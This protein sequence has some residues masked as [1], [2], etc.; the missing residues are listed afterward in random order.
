MAP[1]SHR[2]LGFS[3]RAQY[4]LFLGYVI[5]VAGVLCGIALIIMARFDPKGFTIL[6]GAVLEITAPV[7][8][9]GR[10]G[11]RSVRS[12]NDAVYAYFRAGS[13]NAAL[14]AELKTARAK[15]IQARAIARENA[16]L[17]QLL[18]IAD[19]PPAPIAVTRIIGST[20]SNSQRLA[21]LAAGSASGVHS[22]Q[23]VRGAEGLIGRVT[24]VGLNFSYVL[25]ITDSSST[26]PIV[27]ARSGIAALATGTGDGALELKTLIAG[28]TP[29]RRGDLIVTSGAGGIYPPNIPVGVVISTGRDTAIARP[30]ADPSRLDFAMV[31]PIWH[32]PAVKLSKP[33]PQPRTP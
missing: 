33:V 16:R 19:A 25:L 12:A 11:V 5:A 4:G 17:K 2:R 3:R 1:P 21:T 10:A 14:T 30:L 26:T 15:L 9:A 28:A 6:R 18:R 31:Q 8:D 29:F 13:Q 24:G 27:L 22:G 32:V 20:G 7:A 23:P